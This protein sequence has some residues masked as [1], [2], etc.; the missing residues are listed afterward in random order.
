MLG[1]VMPTLG[2][3]LSRLWE[4]VYELADFR[5]A[6]SQAKSET[7]SEVN[8]IDSTQKKDFFLDLDKPATLAPRSNPATTGTIRL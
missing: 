8:G 5:G 2:S 4:M 1:E 3:A 6:V 7:W